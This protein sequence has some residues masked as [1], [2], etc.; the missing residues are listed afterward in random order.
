MIPSHPT[1]EW[2]DSEWDAWFAWRRWNHHKR[3]AARAEEF[4][5]ALEAGGRLVEC[6]PSG[7][8]IVWP[9]EHYLSKGSPVE[10]ADHV[11]KRED[12]FG[13]TVRIEA[14]G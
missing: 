1:A 13:F 3:R 14:P 12:G 8:E 11:E 10:I 7:I 9:I 2:T 4:R 5:V 6:L